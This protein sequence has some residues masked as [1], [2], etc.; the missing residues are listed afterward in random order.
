MCCLDDSVTSKQNHLR[1]KII[2]HL[3]NKII[4]HG[5][6]NP[7]KMKWHIIG[8]ET[9]RTRLFS[10][11]ADM[12]PLI[13]YPFIFYWSL[14]NC[15]T[16]DTLVDSSK[17]QGLTYF[18]RTAIS[19]SAPNHREVDKICWKYST[20]RRYVVRVASQMYSNCIWRILHHSLPTKYML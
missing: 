6:G 18:Y 19:S 14:I 17:E 13:Q 10:L 20:N 11:L 12:P 1:N 5:Y 3:R 9:A 15:D 7:W 16:G 8:L 4:V 2:V